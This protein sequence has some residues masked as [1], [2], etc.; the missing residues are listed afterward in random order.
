MPEGVEIEIYRLSAEEVVGRTIA[1]AMAC[2]R[3][4]VVAAAG[5]AAELFTEGRHALGVTPGDPSALASALGRLARD[6]ALREGLGHAAGLQARAR[7][8]RA[9]LAHEV[10]AVPVATT[11]VLRP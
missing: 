4:L 9:R 3:A 7:F 11:P 1:E 10:G 6:S 5:G 2:E 8:D